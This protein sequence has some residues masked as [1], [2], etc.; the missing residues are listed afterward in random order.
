MHF[1]RRKS[2]RQG[3]YGDDASLECRTRQS[4]VGAVVGAVEVAVARVV[5]AGSVN[6]R[7]AMLTGNPW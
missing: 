4:P 7:E 1:L 3:G 2:E 6:W 5:P